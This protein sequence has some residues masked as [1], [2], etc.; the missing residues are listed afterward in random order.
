[1]LKLMMDTS[2]YMAN[3]AS[4]NNNN[5]NEINKK[6]LQRSPSPEYR[7]P[8]I[9]LDELPEALLCEC[10]VHVFITVKISLEKFSAQLVDNPYICRQVRQRD[11][12]KQL[13]Y[14]SLFPVT[15]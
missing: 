9:N 11:L 1:M 8:P 7:V 2:D 13:K 10:H 15:S 6:D 14:V 3:L 12:Q 4:V 5:N